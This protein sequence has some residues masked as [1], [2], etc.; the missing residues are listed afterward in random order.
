MEDDGRLR[1]GSRREPA[2]Q[3][4]G[5]LGFHVHLHDRRWVPRRQPVRGQRAAL[6][7]ERGTSAGSHGSESYDAVEVRPG[8]FFVSFAHPERPEG[9]V[10]VVDTNNGHFLVGIAALTGAT[11]NIDPKIEPTLLVGN[12]DE[13]P[14]AGRVPVPSRDLVGKRV[15]FRYSAKQAYEHIYVTSSR[16]AW[17]ALE[18]PQAGHSD[19]EL[20]KTYLVDDGLYFFTWYE[21]IIPTCA[22][23]L[24]DTVA[25]PVDG[26][27]LR[28]VRRGPG[29]HRHGRGVVP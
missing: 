26:V 13:C 5:T 15:L 22:M 6:R 20:T 3:H 18:G 19:V 10:Q 14:K 8:V 1:P 21:K 17:H 11:N 12:I 2:A 25:R 24:F 28:V 27:L 16:F 29:S 23:F 4:D 7:H 9:V